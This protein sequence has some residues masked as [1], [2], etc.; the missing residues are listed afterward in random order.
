MQHD[1]SLMKITLLQTE[2]QWN[3]PQQ[4]SVVA[5]QLMQSALGAD[6]YLLPE[7]WNTGFMISP[8][9]PVISCEPS[10]IWMQE[11]AKKNHCALAGSMY[12]AL[13]DSNLHEKK[14]GKRYTNRLFF[15]HPNANTEHYDK[16][17]L[18]SPGQEHLRFMPG[19]ERKIVCYQDFRILLLT[20]YDLRFPVWARNKND[21]D[22]ILI[23]AN[24]PQVRINAWNVLLKAR[25]IENQCYVLACNRVGNDP[26]T[27][28][29][30]HSQIISPTGEVIA[31]ANDKPQALTA[32]ITLQEVVTARKKFNTLRDADNFTI[33]D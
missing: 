7:M 18:F 10:I 16:R 17:H 9:E 15:V 21:Y 1:N 33:I 25:A 20:C 29:N 13:K 4:N 6:L 5:E 14:E 3:E 2:I 22:A 30:G 19:T 28:Y 23:V 27:S 12:Y 26:K 24:W 11:M 31:L 32:E 8:K